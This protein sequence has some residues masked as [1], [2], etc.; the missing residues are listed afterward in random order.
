MPRGVP[1]Y[2]M[3]KLAPPETFYWGPEIDRDTAMSL[4]RNRYF[5]GEPCKWGHVSERWCLS[6]RCVECVLRSHR[7]EEYRQYTTPQ[8]REWFAANPDRVA[9]YNAQRRA[10]KAAKPVKSEARRDGLKRHWVERRKA[11]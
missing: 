1:K 7:T 6:R 4:G 5:T 11:G 9:E 10:V 3:I 8:E 2:P